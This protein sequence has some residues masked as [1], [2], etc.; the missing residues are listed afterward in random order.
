MSYKEYVKAP[1]DDMVP[2]NDRVLIECRNREWFILHIYLSCNDDPIG[3]RLRVAKVD[4]VHAEYGNCPAIVKG[5]IFT[6]VID[7]NEATNIITI[8]IQVSPWY[9]MNQPHN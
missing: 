8:Y 9:I 3:H 5:W 6:T 2:R 4:T 7:T 1:F